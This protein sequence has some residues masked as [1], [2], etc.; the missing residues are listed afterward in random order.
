MAKKLSLHRRQTEF[1]SLKLCTIP[2]ET[3]S[4]FAEDLCQLNRCLVPQFDVI[5][6]CF[7]VNKTA[8]KNRTRSEFE[9]SYCS[10]CFQLC[11]ITMGY[12]SRILCSNLV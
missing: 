9:K 6:R 3:N 11:E 5:P 2:L 8:V 7:A 4:V 1:L 12:F 10:H